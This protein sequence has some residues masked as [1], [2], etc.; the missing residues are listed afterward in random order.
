MLLLIDGKNILW[1]AYSVLGA[2]GALRGWLKSARAFFRDYGPGQLIVCWDAEDGTAPR[3]RL[4]PEYKSHRHCDTK[5]DSEIDLVEERLRVLLSYLGVLQ[6]WAPEAEADDVMATLAADSRNHEVR[7]LTADKDL[8]QCVTPFVSVVRPGKAALV[9]PAVVKAELGVE[10]HQV[11]DWK[12]LVGDTSDNIPGA[13]GIGPV[14]AKKILEWYPTV[15]AALAGFEQ[16]IPR[17]VVPRI[18]QALVKSKADVR[19]SLKLATINAH[20]EVQRLPRQTD[21]ARA[22]RVLMEWSPGSYTSTR[23]ELGDWERIGVG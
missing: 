11:P 3:L 17:A 16:V 18:A 19:L 23:L 1:R 15:E 21:F 13:L 4:F 12:A 20:V 6:A 5:K 2:E 10:P 9:T 8:W 7:I 22:Q 14:A